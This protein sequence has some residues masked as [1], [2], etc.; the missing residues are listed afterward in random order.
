[1]YLI[2]LQRHGC[3]RSTE[4]IGSFSRGRRLPPSPSA[5][6]SEAAYSAAFAVSR[7]AIRLQGYLATGIHPQ[8]GVE[9]VFQTRDHPA[10]HIG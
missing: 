6:F 10:L 2:E 9:G 8:I 7:L 4:T 1:M 3:S 5:G